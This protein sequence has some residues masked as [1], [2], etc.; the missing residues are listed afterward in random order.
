[1][2]SFGFLERTSDCQVASAGVVEHVQS[3]LLEMGQGWNRR[4]GQTRCTHQ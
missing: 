3:V 2:Q 4:F 1:L